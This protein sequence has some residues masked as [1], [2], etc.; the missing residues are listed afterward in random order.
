MESIEWYGDPQMN[1]IRTNDGYFPDTPLDKDPTRPLGDPNEKIP[2]TG[3]VS[4]YKTVFLQRLANPSAPYDPA[5]NPYLTVDWMPI[6][7]TIFNGEEDPDIPRIPDP[8]E[9]ILALQLNTAVNFA[10]RQRG[11]T[12]FSA[13]ESPFSPGVISNP[14]KYKNNFWAPYSNAPVGTGPVT[15]LTPQPYFNY[16]LVHSLGYLNQAFQPFITNALGKPAELYGDPATQPFPWL[17]WFGRPYVSQL[18]LML[19]PASHP[20]RLLW[21]FQPCR[22]GITNNY[23][24]GVL[25]RRHSRNCSISSSREMRTG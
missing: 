6:D 17:P 9:S 4:N 1:P 22:P 8:T 23:Q 19:V 20:A 21:E 3:T 25:A 13:T 2:Y 14:D 24:P 16:N 5:T 12:N 7:L 18:E 11:I 10:T 15:P